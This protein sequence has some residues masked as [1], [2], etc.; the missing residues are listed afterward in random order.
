VDLSVRYM[1]NKHLPDKA[2]DLL[3]EACARKST[4]LEKLEANDEYKNLEKQ[5]EDLEKEIEI[6]I[7][8]QDYFRAANLKKEVE[9]LKQKMKQV[10]QTVNLPYHLR[11]KVIAEDIGKVLADKL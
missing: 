8:Q 5:L 3:D 1:M 11:P 9:L 7:K 10:R 4:T 6:A 2:I